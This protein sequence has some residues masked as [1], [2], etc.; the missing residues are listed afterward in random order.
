MK[1]ALIKKGVKPGDKVL[2]KLKRDS[3]PT[4]SMW[5]IIKA[6]AAF[7]PVDPEYREER[8]NYIECV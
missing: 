8:I 7:I 3:N 4:A 1:Y 5:G 6:G 2:F